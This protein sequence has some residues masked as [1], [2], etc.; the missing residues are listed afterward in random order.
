[1]FL[2]KLTV[3]RDAL[4]PLAGGSLGVDSTQVLM[5]YRLTT[6]TK[7]LTLTLGRL[8]ILT[9]NIVRVGH[10]GILKCIVVLLPLTYR[11]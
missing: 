9:V 4:L 7:L 3:D 10:G 8:R 11:P 5:I 1:M 6:L 2:L